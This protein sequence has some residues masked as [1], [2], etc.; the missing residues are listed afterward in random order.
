M[1]YDPKALLEY[2]RHS[3]GTMTILFAMM[4]WPSLVT[5]LGYLLHH[6]HILV[7]IEQILIGYLLPCWIIHQFIDKSMWV[8]ATYKDMEGNRKKRIINMYVLG[9]FIGGILAAI[10]II[11]SKFVPFGPAAIILQMPYYATAWREIFYW[12]GFIVL[13]VFLL[14]PAEVL[15]FFMFQRTAWTNKGTDFLICGCYM[16]MN[17]WWI[18]FVIG[19]IWSILTLTGLSFGVGFLLIYST[20]KKSGSQ[21]VGLRMGF[22]IGV[23][24][25]LIFLN[26]VHPSVER[27]Y[28]YARGHSGNI[29]RQ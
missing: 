16:L 18:L 25:L 6:D 8:Q 13:W 12:A 27:P 15:F 9:G 3:K 4:L 20:E 11:W 10:F 23:V 5:G 2:N 7:M 14:P 1:D 17:F 19:N 24:G 28:L 22:A 26:F 29:F 21:A